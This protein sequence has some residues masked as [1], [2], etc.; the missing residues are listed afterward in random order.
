M[1]LTFLKKRWQK[2]LFSV[3]LG[4]F[5]VI[6][7]LAYLV[8]NYWSPIVEQRIKSAIL[9][10]TD[11][12]YSINFSKASLHVIQGKIVIDK[13]ELKP[14]TAVYN[15]RKKQ[16]LAPNS[17][18]HLQVKRLAITHIHP[19]RLYFDDKLDIAQI[20]VS[21]PNLK[22]EYEQNR[23]QDT[24]L[25]GKKTPYQLISK[26]LKS[27]HVKT[28]LLNDVTFK[29]TDK[30][31]S[32]PDVT[33]FKELNFSTDDFL[34]DSLSQ[35]DKSRFLFCKDVSTELHNY[36]GISDDKRYNY[37]IKLIRFST[38][39]RQL[40][41]TGMSYLPIKNPTEF[42]KDTPGDCFAFR[43]DSLRLDNFDFKQYS[44]FHKLY[45]SNLAL[46]DGSLKI[47]TNPAP[48]DTTKDKSENFP[49][50]LL[51]R[52]KMDVRIDTIRISKAAVYYTEF[53]PNSNQPGALSFNNIS[54]I[55]LNV[56]NN[57]AALQKNNI[58]TAKL[59]T[60]FMNYGNLDAQLAFNLTDPKAQFSY[61]GHMTGMDLRKV[62]PI[63]MPLALV[64]IT[65]G[66]L[67][68]LDFD[69]RADKKTARGK[70]Q[71]LYNNLKIS[72]LKKDENDKLKKMGIFSL[73]A[74]ALVIKRNNPTIGEPPRSFNINYTRKTSAS[75]FT[76][77]WK[78]LF[79]GIKSCAGYDASTE[80][81][82]KK[83]INEYQ[84]N[85]VEHAAKKAQRIQR[86]ME[87]RQRRALR[88]QAREARKQQE[89][90]DNNRTNH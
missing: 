7:V 12:L 88:R 90:S 55:F 14:D 17:L 13:I 36:N 58:A 42:F 76:F 54:G 44:K 79:M 89:A 71:L 21:M 59:K 15:R 51:G 11:S 48:N 45:G 57:K 49:H 37:G 75:I 35:Q 61:K 62:N 27:I 66:K 53:N 19:L 4:L 3:T 68:S 81:A 31:G 80:A 78:S 29:Y 47:F 39:S 20:V 1:A 18:Y 30:S 74:N 22:V 33:E 63:T 56:T 34:L 38:R 50:V 5:I 84:S 26:V 23:D 2:I 9:K 6:S 24:I 16:H 82:V 64:K 73:L 70:L 8:N 87:R 86:R 69:M 83:K 40:N 72:I 65:S 85:K 77:M 28:I 67:N 32:K 10:S 46:S 41:I 60:A 52:L 25:T 43:L